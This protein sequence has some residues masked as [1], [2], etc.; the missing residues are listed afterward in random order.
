MALTHAILAFLIKQPASG[1]DL[2][3]KFNADF[4]QF[5]KASQQQVYRDLTK[6]ESQGLIASEVVPREGVFDKK[7]Y[8]ITEAGKQFLKQWMLQ[9]CDPAV[10]RE[11]LLLKMMAGELVPLQVLREEVERHRWLHLEVLQRYKQIERD[12][13]EGKTL[14]TG[15]QLRYLALKRG[16]RYERDWVEWCDE[17]LTE[18]AA[19]KQTTLP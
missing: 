19:I 17:A 6:L 11:E 14:S 15:L 9:P 10:V 12:Y 16:I 4:A 7:L 2:A 3:K 8:S 13:Y 5:W 18:I 1:Y